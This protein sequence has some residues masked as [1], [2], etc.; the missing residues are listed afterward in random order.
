MRID[1][2]TAIRQV[3]AGEL[4]AYWLTQHLD[5]TGAPPA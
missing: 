3:Q 4:V 2:R 1:T 5:V